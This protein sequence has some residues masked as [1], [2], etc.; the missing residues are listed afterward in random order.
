MVGSLGFGTGL[1]FVQN[2]LKVIGTIKLF[3]DP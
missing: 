2:L 1:V 3:L